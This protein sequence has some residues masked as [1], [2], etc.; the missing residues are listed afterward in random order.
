MLPSKLGEPH[1][2][3]VANTLTFRDEVFPQDVAMTIVLDA[4]LAKGLVPSGFTELPD[5]R[6]YH[7]RFEGTQ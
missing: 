7:Y 4:L 5:G 1:S 3:F 6:Q 2:L